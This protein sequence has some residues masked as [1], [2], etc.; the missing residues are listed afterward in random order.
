MSRPHL[1]FLHF[2]GGSARSWH[3]VTERLPGF[4][5]VT[6]DL[7][8]FGDA[9]G[10]AGHSVAEM[11]DHVAARIRAVAPQRWLLVG[12]SMGAKVAAA[13]ARRAED[14]EAGLEGL[15]GLVLLAGSPPG[16]EPIPDDKRAEMAGWFAGDAETSRGEAHEYI[17]RNAGRPL[18]D[19]R[20]RQAAEEVL[21]ADRAAWLAWL[22][23]G[24]REDWASRIGVLRSPALLVFGGQDADLGQAAQARLSLPHFA[25]GRLVALP[26]AGHLLPLEQPDAVAAL[27]ASFTEPRPD[28]EYAALI[29]SDRVSD[30]T[31]AALQARLD[32]P[33]AALISAAHHAMLRAVLD[34]VL[35]QPPGV[36]IDLATRIASQWSMGDGWRF[37]AL[38]PD[39]EAYAAA[40]DALD[41]AARRRHGAGLVDLDA[42]AMDALLEALEAGKLDEGTPLRLWFGDLRGDAAKAFIAHPVGMQR[43]GYDGFAYEPHGFPRPDTVEAWEPRAS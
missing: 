10:T 43:I 31:R 14:G 16:P 36:A 1:V 37:D 19:T 15:A 9:A 29:A 34:R 8:G 6:V 22:R 4:E 28:A 17:A 25:R 38:P 20:H 33:S 30:A 23:D 32:P 27:I 41:A 12:H 39:A 11:A 13:L 18:D 40:L 2:L 35:P 42:G 21:R 24:S 3:G 7:P 5:H 26:E